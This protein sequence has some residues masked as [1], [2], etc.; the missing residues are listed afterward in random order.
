MALEYFEIYVDFFKG[1]QGAFFLRKKALGGV[2]SVYS[3]S[4]NA[5]A[6]L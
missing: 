5:I 6:V 4:Q 2:L 3:N 1:V